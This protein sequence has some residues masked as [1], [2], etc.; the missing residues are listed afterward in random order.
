MNHR[1]SNRQH[2]TNLQNANHNYRHRNQLSHNLFYSAPANTLNKRINLNKSLYNQLLLF[3]RIS[4]E[5]F[6]FNSTR[7][8]SINKDYDEYF[9]PQ[10][11]EFSHTPANT[12]ITVKRS[13]T[14][15]QDIERQDLFAWK[16]EFLQVV[17]Q[18]N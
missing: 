9:T 2:Q 14:M 5:S 16:N 4:P 13:F 12:T 11:I 1:R 7:K 8:D 6:K 3:G 18:A 10:R 15:L 17:K